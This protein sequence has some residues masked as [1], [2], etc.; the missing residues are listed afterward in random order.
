VF[1]DDHA[2]TAKAISSLASTYQSR[3]RYD[4]SEQLELQVVEG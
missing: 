3:G 1:G 2:E 4:D